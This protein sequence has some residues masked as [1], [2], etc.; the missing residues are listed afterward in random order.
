MTMTLPAVPAWKRL[1]LKLKYANDL[2]GSP[3][4]NGALSTHG[5]TK[6][7][8]SRQHDSGVTELPKKKRKIESVSTGAA[9]HPSAAM[10]PP[11]DV[12]ESR[13]EAI[14]QSVKKQVSFTSDTKEELPAPNDERVLDAAEVQVAKPSKKS[15]KRSKKTQNLPPQK[16]NASLDYL[17][18]YATAK[19]NWKFN[20]NRDT[21]ILKHLFSETDISREYDFA[22]AKYIHGLQGTGARERLKKQCLVMLKEVESPPDGT[23]STEITASPEDVERFTQRFKSDLTPATKSCPEEEDGSGG[24]EEYK[25]WVRDQPRAKILMWALGLSHDPLPLNGTKSTLDPGISTANGTD[26]A[27]K[28]NTKKR[29]NRT[30]IVEYESSSSSSSASES[31][32]ESGSDSDSESDLE[33]IEK[34]RT[35]R[36]SDKQTSNSDSDEDTSSSDSDS[37]SSSDAESEESRRHLGG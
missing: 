25:S 37:E 7:S 12:V 28:P 3:P 15:K 13:R 17:T 23:D 31:E 10:N 26:I 4:T 35:G 11:T 27:A 6:N 33:K 24:K 16:P 5:Q 14:Q 36:Q 32:S 20:K 18:Q 21:W 1:G 34:T 19:S 30:A 22:L 2:P 29:K 8:T 9:K